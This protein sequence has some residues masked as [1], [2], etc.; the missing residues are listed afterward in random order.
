MTGKGASRAVIR[1]I[2]VSGWQ[3]EI[4]WSRVAADEQGIEFAFIKATEGGHVVDTN[5][6]G[7]LD[8][9]FEAN[10]S[11]ATD[12]GL[13]VGAYHFAR[14]SDRTGTGHYPLLEDAR[15]EASWLWTVLERAGWDPASHLPPVLDIEWDERAT[16]AGITSEQ[17]RDWALEFIAEL[18]G[19]CGHKPLVY[20]GPSFWRYKLLRDERFE[21]VGLWEVDIN[22]PAGRPRDIPGWSWSFHQYSFEGRVDGIR[23]N[24]DLNVFRGSRDELP[25]GTE[26]GVGLEPE[27]APEGTPPCSLGLPVVALTD[28]PMPRGA[29]VERI[30]ALLMAHGHGP[31]GLAGPDGLPDGLGG[32]K[33]SR[34]VERFQWQAG[35][36]PSRV[37]DEA[38]WWALLT[39][40]IDLP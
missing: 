20:T 25:A 4:D 14:V 19:L 13:L 33:T 21:E 2:D 24:V 27:P 35:L 23:G 31:D 39:S 12:A 8:R 18:T 17:T 10:W 34:A 26:A 29:A 36:E 22:R 9:C 38:T 11:G 6:G 15:S 28:G 5:S 3:G 7:F 16:A 40:G 1:G 30:Q 32:R 37:V